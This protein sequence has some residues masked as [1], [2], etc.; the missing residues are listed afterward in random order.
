MIP[1]LFIAY[2][3][4]K[5]SLGRSADG[6][7]PGTLKAPALF[8]VVDHP[9]PFGSNDT[10]TTSPTFAYAIDKLGK[11]VFVPDTATVAV[12]A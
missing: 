10:V 11:V 6:M 2:E 1:F 8:L 5:K 12:P 7:I 3:K 4:T 9:A